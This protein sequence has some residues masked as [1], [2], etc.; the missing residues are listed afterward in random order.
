MNGNVDL[1]LGQSGEAKC[2]TQGKKEYPTLGQAFKV[3]WAG[4]P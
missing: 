2:N 1:K 3:R 4:R